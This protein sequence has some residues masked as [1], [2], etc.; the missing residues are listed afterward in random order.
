MFI[1]CLLS[2]N[3]FIVS[4][5]SLFLALNE[6][7]T[8][9]GLKKRDFSQSFLVLLPIFLNIFFLHF[10]TSSSASLNYTQHRQVSTLRLA[11]I[12]KHLNKINKP[13][14][15]TIES[16][17]G[18]I[19]DCVHKRKQ[20]ALDHPLLKNH[21]IQKVAPHMPK[22]KM[23]KTDELREKNSNSSRRWSDTV[24]WQRWHERGERC[25]K[26]TVPVRRSTVHDVLRAKSL[27]DFGKK[28]R[29]VSQLSSRRVDAP[30]VVSGNGHEHAIA[31]TGASEE[32]YGAKATINVWNPEVEMVNEFSLSQIWVLSGSFDGSDLNSI[33]AG[34]QSG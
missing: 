34:W 9:P 28:K 16:P 3:G 11:R 29:R 1:S 7:G 24:A 8:V 18:D 30:D 13:P 15:F 17:D 2:R 33:E 4:T 22:M 25:P 14:V 31:F 10:G 23:V 26:G 32:V 27:F 12:E 6:M 20:P 21:K 19:I 5:V